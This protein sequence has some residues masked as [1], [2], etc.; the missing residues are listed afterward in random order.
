VAVI[1]FLVAGSARADKLVRIAG[2]GTED[3]NVPATQWKL[4]QPFGIDFDKDGNSYIVEL[5]GDRVLKVDP[6]GMFTILAGT[7]KKGNTG[8]DG[9]ALQAPLTGLPRLAVPP[10]GTIYAADT[11]NNRVRKIDPASGKI[12]AFAGTSK[13]G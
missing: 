9:P 5:Q 7:G 11:W 2:G 6:K 8:D 12:T 1:L 10:E 3:N 4:I 13:K